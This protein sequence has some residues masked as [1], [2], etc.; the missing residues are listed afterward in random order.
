MGRLYIETGYEGFLVVENPSYFGTVFTFQAMYDG[1]FAFV[2]S[3]YIDGSFASSE[4][5]YWYGACTYT[6]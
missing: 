3:I 1:I 2:P 4:V 5:I 6:P